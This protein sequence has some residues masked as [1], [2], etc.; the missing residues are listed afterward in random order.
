MFDLT[1][2]SEPVLFRGANR[3][4]SLYPELVSQLSYGNVSWGKLVS[5]GRGCTETRR[6]RACLMLP[7]D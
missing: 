7:E 2:S 1:Y 4:R 3:S 6:H 5:V